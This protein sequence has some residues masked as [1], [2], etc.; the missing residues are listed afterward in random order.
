LN[1]DIPETKFNVKIY[2]KDKGLRVAKSAK[3]A[4]KGVVSKKKISILQ[5]DTI[6]CPV[7][8]SERSFVECFA[9]ESFIRRVTGEVHCS[10]IKA[11]IFK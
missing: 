6:H 5:K 9:C 11:T 10:G 3:E 8:D 4:L 1:N 7:L 2:Q